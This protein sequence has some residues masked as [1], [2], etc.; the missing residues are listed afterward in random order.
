MDDVLVSI[1]CKYVGSTGFIASFFIIIGQSAVAM[2]ISQT[3][4]VEY[5]SCLNVVYFPQLG[6]FSFPYE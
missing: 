3:V 5:A 4:A 6:M 2:Q 1:S